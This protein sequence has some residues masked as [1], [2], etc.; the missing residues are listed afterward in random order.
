MRTLV[1]IPILLVLSVALVSPAAA[2]NFV[3]HLS[4]EEN[5]PTENVA[6]LAEGQFILHESRAG[7]L[8]FRLILANIEGV[9]AAH[10]HCAP[11]GVAGPVGVTLFFFVPFPGFPVDVNGTLAAGPIVE[12]DSGNSCGW[13][14]NADL[15][16][17]IGDGEAYVN[18]HTLL[19]MPGEVRGQLQ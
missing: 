13:I 9:L 15:I 17:A 2:G 8:S 16:D 18:V 19:N 11:V 14:D 10:I 5:V 7:D 6:T 1:T 12:P 3:A 4:Q